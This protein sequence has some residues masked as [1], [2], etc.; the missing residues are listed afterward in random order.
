MPNMTF[1][2]SAITLFVGLQRQSHLWFIIVFLFVSSFAAAD[3]VAKL[4]IEKRIITEKEF[5]DRLSA[6]RSLYQRIL[7]RIRTEVVQPI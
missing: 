7:N 6:E 2:D 1:D 5:Y 4:L 3:A